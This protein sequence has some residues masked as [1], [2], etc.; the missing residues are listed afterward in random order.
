MLAISSERKRAIAQ[1]WLDLTL[2]TYPSQTVKFLVRES[3]RFH[4]PVGQ[5]LKEG[6]PLLVDELFGGM[7]SARVGQALED[8]VRIRAVQNFSARDAV[9]FVFLLKGVI[10]PELSAD[11]ADRLELDSRI[12]EL[13]LSAFD[14]YAQCRAKIS[15]VQVNEARRGVALLNRIYSEVGGR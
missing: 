15:G 9:A 3:D 6:I 7:D 14:F 13:A 4:N 10:Q 11:G 1:Q 8:I 12:D 2:R 5:T